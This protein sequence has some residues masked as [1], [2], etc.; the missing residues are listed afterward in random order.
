L[1][2]ALAALTDLGGPGVLKPAVRWDGRTVVRRVAT[3]GELSAAWDELGGVSCTLELFAPIDAELAVLVARSASGA[4]AAYP[5]AE[6]RRAERDGTPRLLWS[7]IPAI[8]PVPHAEKARRLATSI[9]ERLRV[10]GLLAVE[11]FLLTDG[12]LVVN[13]LVPCPH[14]T[15][16]AAE[17]ACATGQYEQLVRAICDLPLGPTDVVRPTAVAPIHADEWQAGDLRAVE[18]VLRLGG[19]T[20]RASAIVAPSSA[21]RVGHLAATGQTPD[22]AVTRV[23]QARTI[24]RS[25]RSHPRAEHPASHAASAGAGRSASE[26]LATH[27]RR[28]V[29]AMP[30]TG[31]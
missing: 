18:A 9:A 10:E 28:A 6:S 8:C 5:A 31:A 26:S 12:R 13:E 30:P 11:L 7:V 27:L 1:D 16:A 4:V 29:R 23:L 21:Q 20:L 3:P 19:V 25:R 17:Q 15:F 22:Q 2:E 24:L 14:P